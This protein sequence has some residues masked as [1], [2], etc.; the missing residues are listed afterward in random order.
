MNRRTLCLLAAALCSASAWSQDGGLVPPASLLQPL[1]R[2]LAFLLRRLHRPALQPARA[3]QP[4]Q[5]QAADARL[6]RADEQH[7]ARRGALRFAVRTCCHGL[8]DDGGRRGQRRFPGRSGI[9]EGL[10]AG[11]RTACS[12]SPRPI[13]SG[14]STRRDGRELW[15]YFWKTRGGTHIANRG[16]ALWKDSLLFETPDNYLVSLDARTGKENWHVEIASLEQQYFST[17]AP[18]V[19]GDLVLVGTGND[20][21]APGFLQAFDAATGKLAWK[22]YMV[23]MNP[24]RCGPRHLAEPRGRAPWRRHSVDAGLLRSGDRSLHHR[25]R[26]SDAGLHR[27]R[28]QG[29]QPVH[30]FAGR[31]P[32]EDRRARLVLPDVAAR[33]ARLGFGADAGPVRR[34]DR[35]QAAQAGLDRGA[36]RLLLHAR[37]R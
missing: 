21:D 7:R 5:R 32:R 10:G 14:R 8:P 2:G 15:H 16:A 36:Q 9:D 30:L 35:R 20:L 25:H 11:G 24:G 17:M 31:D 29:R 22:T 1:A 33:H 12:T 3:A 37:S 4:R 34:H 28:A 23:P 26:Q 27:R 6:D 19:I 18:V 13:T